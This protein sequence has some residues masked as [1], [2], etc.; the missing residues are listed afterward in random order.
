VRD[1]IFN[2]PEHEFSRLAQHLTQETV[3]GWLKAASR[4]GLQQ[5]V[6]LCIDFVVAKQVSI[7]VK[8]LSGLATA[9]ADQLLFAM[10]KKSTAS[11]LKIASCNEMLAKV[12]QVKEN[13]AMYRCSH[14]HTWAA[15]G[16]VSS[17]ER[18]SR[19]CSINASISCTGSI[20]LKDLQRILQA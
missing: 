12:P 5:A 6:Q 11:R 14:G 10:H 13:I 8:D 16:S 20:N 19:C 2:K 18:C 9:D 17:S 15:L 1:Y 4:C 3:V 7:R